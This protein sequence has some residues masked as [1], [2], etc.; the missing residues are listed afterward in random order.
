MDEAHNREKPDS[1]DRMYTRMMRIES[2]SRIIG[3]G[4]GGGDGWMAGLTAENCL[5]SGKINPP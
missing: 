5:G 3:R 4:G 2:D 1:G